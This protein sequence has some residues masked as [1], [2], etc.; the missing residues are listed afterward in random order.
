MG[1]GKCHRRQC[2]WQSRSGCLSSLASSKEREQLKPGIYIPSSLEW[3]KQR[4]GLGVGQGADGA[5]A[6]W[7]LLWELGVIWGMSQRCVTVCVRERGR[8][9]NTLG[10]TWGFL[11]WLSCVSTDRVTQSLLRFL[12]PCSLES[13]RHRGI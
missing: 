11:P 13:L 6:G 12:H 4:Q 9:I 3:R 2:G 5:S 8:E 7:V 1:V 10:C